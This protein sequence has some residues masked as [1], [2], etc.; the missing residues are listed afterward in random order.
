MAEVKN[1]FI[2]GATGLLG[3]RLVKSL[4]ERGGHHL[5]LG[6]RSA[7]QYSLFPDCCCKY[8]DLS[9]TLSFQDNLRNIDIVIHLAGMNSSE[10]E[11]FPEDAYSY[12]AKATLILARMAEES[13]VKHFIIISS[14]HVYGRAL[15]GIV[16][17]ETKPEPLSVYAKSH[18]LKEEML[19]SLSLHHMRITILRLANSIGYPTFKSVNCWHLLVNNICRQLIE[20]NKIILN[21]DMKTERDFIPVSD[22]IKALGVVMNWDTENSSFSV[23][24]LGSGY[25]MSLM[26]IVEKVVSVYD[27]KEWKSVD[28]RYLSEQQNIN[29]FNF[30]INKILL[31]G[32]QPESDYEKEIKVLLEYSKKWFGEKS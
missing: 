4:L 14:Y 27:P 29:H 16:T 10:C 3:G 31:K 17:E 32:F 6:I 18:L 21:S 22:V 23:Y 30:S 19:Q 12:N 2:S 15:T 9:D 28:I 24:N 11:Q 8:F 7:F 5:F 26:E 20:T 1:L 25:S 13:G